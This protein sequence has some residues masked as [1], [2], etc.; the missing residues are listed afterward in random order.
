MAYLYFKSYYRDEEDVSLIDQL[1]VV[2]EFPRVFE[3]SAGDE[4]FPPI[5]MEELKAIVMSSPS[6]K[7][8]G[9]HGWTC[10]LF[11]T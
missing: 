10:E 1:R 11:K 6:S 2:K 4:L 3:E 8:P 7:I 9:P 5:Q